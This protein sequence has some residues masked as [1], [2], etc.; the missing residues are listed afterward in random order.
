M[1]LQAS[2]QLIVIALTASPLL[3]AEA[4]GA[5]R[6]FPIDSENYA[7]DTFRT[8]NPILEWDVSNFLVDLSGHYANCKVINSPPGVVSVDRLTP[9]GET[10]IGVVDY[11]EGR[12]TD[13]T[14]VNA[15]IQDMI[16]RWQR[17]RLYSDQIKGAEIFGCSVRP[18]CSG[19][20]V[21]ACL[22]TPGH[23]VDKPEPPIR[24]ERPTYAPPPTQKPWQPEPT[25]AHPSVPENIVGIQ[26]AL[27]FTPQQYKEAENVFGRK[28]DRSHYLE[29]LS[30]YE[31][32]CAMMANPDWPFNH[33]KKAEQPGTRITG[34]Y[35]SSRNRGSTPDAL[36]EIISQFKT[37]SNSREIGCSIIPDCI[38]P[39]D[40]QMYVVIACLF[41]ETM[42]HRRFH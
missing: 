15:Y 8:V 16:D 31:T 4:K 12:G 36:Q 3:V 35:G 2:L 10:I 23:G 22:F 17:N 13:S 20:V 38:N 7:I 30:G 33:M 28:W 41:E 29:N 9:L 37:V 26:R 19:H 18:G 14:A 24:T 25:Q 40:G 21:I 32:D 39:Q 42:S 11:M 5:G 34:Q 27:A 1:V 6:A